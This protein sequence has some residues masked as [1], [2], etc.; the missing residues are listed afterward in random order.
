MSTGLAS[1]N[2]LELFGSVAV[3]MVSPF[4]AQ[5][6]LDLKAAQTLASHLVENGIDSLIVSGTTGESPTTTVEEKIQLIEA[7]KEAVGAKAKIIA[8]AGTN[9]TRA[10]V[11]LAQA[12]E[13]AGAD[14]L[15]VV[16][17]YY[18]KPSQ[19]G[20]YLHF[21]EVEQAVSIPICAYDIPGRCGVPIEPDTVRRLAELLGI[22]AVKDA[23][24]NLAEATPLI[25]ET[26]LAW[27]SGDDPLNLPWLSLGA[28][29]FISVIGHLAP[30]ELRALY[31]AFDEGDLHLAQTINAKL[32]PL[33]RA[34][35]RFG[36]VSLAKAGLK[37]QGINVGEPRLPITPVQENL[38]DDLK[39]AGV[40]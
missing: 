29:G 40:L 18:S 1:T 35:A 10:T 26:G 8:G 36:G 33:V 24:G 7:V 30:R 3:A 23:K 14:G 11:A 25:Q 27:Y 38:E 31:Q 19:E 39:Q 21:K 12:S 22:K 34:Q 16:T 13:Q 28:T 9:N 4:D 20:I 17:P 5:G 37:L 2:G 6:D 32:A 15:L